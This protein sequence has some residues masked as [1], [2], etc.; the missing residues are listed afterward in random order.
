MRP[1]A[2][3]KHPRCFGLGLLVAGLVLGVIS[4]YQVVDGGSG[5][6][7]AVALTP[8]ATLLGAWRLVVGQPW[9]DAKQ[10]QQ[11]WV[12]RGDVVLAVVALAASSAL[13]VWLYRHRDPVNAIVLAGL[14][15]AC[16]LGA[17]Y[18]GL[19]DNRRSTGAS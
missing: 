10:R 7:V 13:L 16:A 9:D 1:A 6:V 17:V 18:I 4:G 11:R 2:R 19:R 12:S 3:L 15:G 8:C 14:L 5:G